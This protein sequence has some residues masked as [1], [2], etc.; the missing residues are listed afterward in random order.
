MHRIVKSLTC[1]G[2]RHCGPTRGIKHMRLLHP[3]CILARMM[4][5]PFR[6]YR[7]FDFATPPE[8]TLY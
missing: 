5:S 6:L 4:L 1:W 8:Q 7:R 2:I 3:A